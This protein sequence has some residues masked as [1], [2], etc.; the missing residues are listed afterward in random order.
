MVVVVLVVVVL[1]VVAVVYRMCFSAAQPLRRL[2]RPSFSR[3]LG[4]EWR[5]L[6]RET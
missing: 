3:G 2:Q 1:V 6:Q 4:W 5:R